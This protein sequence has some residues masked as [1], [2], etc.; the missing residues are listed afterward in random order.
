VNPVQAERYDVVVIGAGPGGYVAAIRAAQLGLTVSIV[1][2][3]RPGGVCLNWGCIPSKA[4]LAAADLYNDI[5]TASGWGIRTGDPAVDY[6]QVIARSREAADRLGRGVASLLKKHKIP[7][8][9]GVGRLGRGETVIVEGDTATEVAADRVIVATGSGERTL[10]GVEI[11]G[12]QVLTSREALE[13]TTF[14]AS[15]VIIGGGAVGVEFAYIYR[16]FGAQVTLVEMEDQLLPGMDADIGAELG[17]AFRRRG[18]EVVTSTRFSSLRRSPSGCEVVLS[19]AEGPRA[20]TAEKVLVAVGRAPLSGGLGLEERG[21]VLEGGF[22]QVDAQLRTASKSLYA[23]GDVSGP[24]LL[25]H[26]ASAQGV[27][28]VEFMVGKRQRP[29][30]PRR[31]PTCV[32]CRPEIASVGL[33]E[34]E[35][36]ASGR[37]VRIGR[38]PFRATGKAVATG[39]MDG[40]VKLVADREDGEILGCH[41]IGDRATELIAEI[42]LGATLGATT[43]EVAATVHAHPT[44]SEAIMEAALAAEGRSINC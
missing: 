12:R 6:S 9:A 36:R 31:I 2:R 40:F 32:Y 3:G 17:R 8:L 34:G 20:I 18:I 22:V 44:L 26:V 30:D 39:H 33:T 1:E 7:L 37:E 27:A 29:V 13:D 4:I 14:P 21:V 5:K 16:A 38:V 35:A 41:I 43:T 28:A 23:I 19:R 42:T 15:V 24:P 10:P 11:D 25:A